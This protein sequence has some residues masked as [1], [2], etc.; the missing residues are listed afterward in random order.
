MKTL[1]TVDDVVAA[2]ESSNLQ[3][4]NKLTSTNYP[5]K[6]IYECGCGEMHRVNSGSGTVFFVAM[7]VKFVMR[8]GNDFATF[9]QVK[10]LFRQS[11]TTLWTCN[12]GIFREAIEK[13]GL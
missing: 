9:F 11:A 13:L 2:L 12:L 4:P 6:V 7:P 5:D 1:N 3:P 8:C 10:G